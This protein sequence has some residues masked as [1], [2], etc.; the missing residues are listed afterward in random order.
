MDLWNEVRTAAYVLRLGTVSAA[1]EALGVHRATVIRHI[2]ALEEAIGGK[3]FQRH[4]RGYTPTDIGVDLA[5]VATTTDDEMRRFFY[6]ARHGSDS[7]NGELIVTSMDLIV[8]TIL[9]AIKHLR[10]QHRGLRISYR[11]SSEIYRLEYG[12]AHVAFRV[13]ARPESLDLVVRPFS[14]LRFGLFA[15]RSY[16]E[17]FGLPADEVDLGDHEISVPNDVDGPMVNWLR[18]QV[19]EERHVFSCSAG[20]LVEQ[21]VVCG[22]GIGF[23]PLHQARHMKDLVRVLPDNEW[24]YP[25]WLVT[26]V[27]LHRAPKVQAL[28]D[29][30]RNSDD[31]ELRSELE[32]VLARHRVANTG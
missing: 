23:V 25:V 19:P 1:A 28:V 24:S 3:L 26:H 20:R 13:G 18:E 2:D 29:Q 14:T 22:L 11:I 10:R 32:F 31:H 27:D 21:S 16:I 30:F 17:Q 15:S 12:E 5:R 8:A 7:L 6:R 4:S 9:P